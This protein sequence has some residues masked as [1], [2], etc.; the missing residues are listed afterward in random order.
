MHSVLSVRVHSCA[1]LAPLSLWHY[2]MAHPGWTHTGTQGCEGAPRS[3]THGSG[4]T[5]CRGVGSHCFST[6]HCLRAGA[7][8]SLHGHSH[9]EGCLSRTPHRRTTRHNTAHWQTGKEG[10]NS[11]DRRDNERLLRSTTR[12]LALT[13]NLFFRF[14][15][16]ALRAGGACVIRSVAGA[17]ARHA[18]GSREG[19]EIARQLRA[20]RCGRR[21]CTGS[22]LRV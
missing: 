3:C 2:F 10:T 22:G 7:R 6:R 18:N 14:C 11:L 20:A 13:C 15:N 12:V 21:G 19:A 4:L 9:S 8:C 5:R 16:G 17:S 1:L